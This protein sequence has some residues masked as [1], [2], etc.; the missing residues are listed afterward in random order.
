MGRGYNNRME[1]IMLF[2]QFGLVKTYFNHTDFKFYGLRKI[3]GGLWKYF[4]GD[5][6][7]PP[8]YFNTGDVH[9]FLHNSFILT[10]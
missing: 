1:K 10:K 3:F 5:P 2:N 8:N 6:S 7:L 9:I 4:L